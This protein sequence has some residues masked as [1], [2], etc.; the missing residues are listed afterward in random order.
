MFKI[1]FKLLEALQNV[2]QGKFVT[3]IPPSNTPNITYA[4]NAKKNQFDGHTSLWLI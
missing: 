4:G 3:S 1:E 2:A